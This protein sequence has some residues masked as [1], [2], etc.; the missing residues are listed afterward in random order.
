M[1]QRI[2]ELTWNCKECDS[3]GI[4]GREKQCPSCGAA[5]ESGE[6]K[7]D[8]LDAKGADGSNVAAT[9]TDSELL[10]LANA[11]KDWFCECCSSGNRGD[12]AACANCGAAKGTPKPPPKAEVPKAA[13]AGVSV[14][15]I[16]GGLAV[17]G[18]LCFGWM[19]WGARP[20][21]AAVTGVHWQHSVAVQ[22]WT[23]TDS[24]GWEDSVVATAEV[25]PVGGVGERAG[26]ALV[27]GSCAMAHFAD[28][29]YICGSD[30]VCTPRYRS[31]TESYSCTSSETY[32][33]GEDCVDNGNGFATCTTKTCTRD[34]PGTCQREVQVPDGEDC[35]NVDRHCSRPINKSQC[36]YS[37][38]TWATVDT[39][40]AEGRD[41]NVTWPAPALGP[42]ARTQRAGTYTVSFGWTGRNG[43]ANRDIHPATIEEWKT[44]SVGEKVSVSEPYVGDVVITRGG[45]EVR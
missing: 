16:L 4:L 37:T 28:E 43:A 12:A 19:W 26:W 15:V 35:Q 21:E 11:G 34:V 13:I 9:V 20:V 2:V 8:G 40:V 38:Q 10:S 25:P 14:V 5:R 1:A 44:W 45:A 27:P 23:P 18:L 24:L 3:K 6:M 17:L 22:Q 36:H 29:D 42:L 39:V 7:M 32:D 33:C 31:S 30:R 41:A